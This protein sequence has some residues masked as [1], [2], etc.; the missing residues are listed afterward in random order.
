MDEVEGQNQVAAEESNVEGQAVDLEALQEQVAKLASQNER[1]LS[2]SKNWAGK[3]RDLRDSVDSQQKQELEKSENWK[4]L[5]EREKQEK[6]D[7]SEQMKSLRE[8]ALRQSLNF[9]VAKY[10]QDAHKVERVIGAVLD[11]DAVQVSDDQTSFMGVKEAIEALRN[12][13]PYLFKQD[14]PVGMVNSNPSGKPP[15]QKTMA[16]MSGHEKDALLKES[17]KSILKTRR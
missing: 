12:D 15:R 11:S 6:F 9:E 1:L 16:E 8:N 17:I 3:Y 13:E 5:L 14:K 2:E 7:L 10:A 4:E